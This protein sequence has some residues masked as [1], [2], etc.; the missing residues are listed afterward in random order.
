MKKILVAVADYPRL[1]GGRAMSFVHVRNRYYVEAGLDVEV[2]NF[3]SKINYEIDGIPVITLQNFQENLKKFQI[4]I[5]HAANLRNHYKFL[6]KYD[7]NFKQIIFIFHGHEILKINEAYP[8]PYDFCRRSLWK[9]KFQDFYDCFK[10]EV[11]RK[12]FLKNSKKIKLIFVSR[13]LYEQFKKNLHL[14]KFKGK[15]YIVHN[16]VGR[17]FEQVSYNV[18]QKKEFDFITIRGNLDDS[19]YGVD[20]VVAMAKKYPKMKFLLIGKGQFFNYNDKPKNLIWVEETL[21]HEKMLDYMDKSKCA[22]F[23]TREDTQGVMACECAT[24][25]MPVITSD[26]DVC[27][28]IFGGM[29]N[30][31]LM[32][33]NIS[34]WNAVKV[35]DR[36]LVNLPYKKNS[37]YYA[38]NTVDKE[39]K[40]IKQCLGNWI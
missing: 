22:L 18:F 2:L 27:R 31:V 20:L 9:D 23:F 1:D 24:Y 16:S 10:F 36:L 5:C 25:G 29:H 35:V 13:W 39:I 28:E 32:P 4:L 3:S 30:V 40:I 19:K 15:T 8:K 11:W 26:I 33:N 6:R 7:I 12:Y 17:I 34:Q 37:M 14:N 21:L 38:K